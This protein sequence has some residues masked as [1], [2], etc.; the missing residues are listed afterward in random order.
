MD[1]TPDQLQDR[2]AVRIFTLFNR[3]PRKSRKRIYPGRGRS[4]PDPEER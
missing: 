1:D 3:A 2:V 4:A